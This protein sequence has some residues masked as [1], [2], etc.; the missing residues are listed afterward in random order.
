MKLDIPELQKTA[1]RIRRDIVEMVWRAGS[2]HIGGS[3]SMVEIVLVL[4]HCIMKVDPKRPDGEDRDRLVLSKG[5]SAACL[6]AVLAEMG[7]FDRKLLFEE[8]IRTHGRLSE[9]PDMQTVPGIDMST[10]SLG[11]G[12]STAV[13][14]AWAARHHRKPIKV[15][16]IMGCGE[17]QE[18]Q[19]WEAAMAAAHHRLDNLVA[20]VDFNNAQVS[21]NTSD[22]MNPQPLPEKYR[23][24]GWDVD[25]VDG[26][27]IEGLV[28][29]LKKPNPAAKP[30][31]IIAKTVK[32]KGVSF[33][34]GDYNF[35]A[36]SLTREQYEQALADTG[37]E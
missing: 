37:S 32:G 23:T 16:A 28:R 11:Q 13:G 10:G 36:T 18:G 22:V 9:H 31:V 29:A 3:L 19:V 34:E 21:G 24:F 17:Q 14:M 35:H 33:M 12:I 7:F 1:R 8:F 5:H 26:H 2:G 20:I 6:Y 15:Y 30:R 25:E 4:Y 27:D